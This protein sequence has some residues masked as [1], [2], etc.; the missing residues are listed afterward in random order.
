MACTVGLCLIFPSR[1]AGEVGNDGRRIDGAS[2]WLACALFRRIRSISKGQRRSALR[3][4][5]HRNRGAIQSRH[6]AGGS[7]ARQ[8]RREACAGRKGA[9]Q[10]HAHLERERSGALRSP[11]KLGEVRAKLAGGY[12][13]LFRNQKNLFLID[14]ADALF[15]SRD[16]RLGHV[17]E[18]GEIGA[19]HRRRLACAVGFERVIFLH[20]R[21]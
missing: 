16:G 5:D 4:L 7:R 20:S 1:G 2:S 18:P 10:M 14:F 12:P 9:R 15:P 19:A 3:R 13:G 11:D 6:F 21:L 17:Q 8:P